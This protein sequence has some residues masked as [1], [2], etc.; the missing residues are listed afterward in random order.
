MSGPGSSGR[1]RRFERGG[2]SWVTLVLLAALA[3]GAAA[4]ER[5]VSYPLLG[6]SDVRTFEVDLTGDLTPPDWGP[7]R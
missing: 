7:A 2:I 1:A 3:A 4:H 5:L 6:W